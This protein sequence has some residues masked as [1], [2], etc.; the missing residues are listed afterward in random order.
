MARSTSQ[1]GNTEDNSYRKLQRGNIVKV[2]KNV[3]EVILKTKTRDNF[4]FFQQN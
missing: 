1:T 4:D 3:E 2:I